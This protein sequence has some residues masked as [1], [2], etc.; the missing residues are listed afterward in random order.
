LVHHGPQPPEMVWWSLPVS[1]KSATTIS[2]RRTEPQTPQHS[3]ATVTRSSS[4]GSRGYSMTSKFCGA[5]CAAS[6]PGEHHTEIYTP[7]S[8][9]GRG[10]HSLTT[11]KP[12]TRLTALGESPILTF[13]VGDSHLG[14]CMCF[15]AG[16]IVG[17]RV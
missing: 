1:T 10:R 11:Y 8:S 4:S 5:Q 9:W 13:G 2:G 12:C 6:M 15:G 17:V 7:G 16:L 14:Q 3:T